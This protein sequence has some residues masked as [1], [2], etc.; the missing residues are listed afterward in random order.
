MRNKTAAHD[1]LSAAAGKSVGRPC[2]DETARQ[3]RGTHV[4]RAVHL[5][6]GLEGG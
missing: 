3:A 4:W 6:T 2:K 1:R 5:L